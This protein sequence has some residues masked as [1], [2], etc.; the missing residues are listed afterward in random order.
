MQKNTTYYFLGAL[1]VFC[2]GVYG[3]F[4]NPFINKQQ[5][6]S[7]VA[8]TTSYATSSTSF[9][10]VLVETEGSGTI[11]FTPGVQNT[12]PKPP[13]IRRT[14]T[15]ASS[16]SADVASLYRQK[17][18]DLQEALLKDSYNFSNWIDVGILYKQVGDYK[19]A[20]EAWNFASVISEK[21]IVS[22]NNLGDLYHYYLKDYPK[23]EQVLVRA[24]RNDE[25]YILSYINLADLYTN[26]YQTNT[27]KAELVLKDGLVKNPGDITL[28]LALGAYYKSR[29]NTESAKTIYNEVLTK[30]KTAKNQNLIDQVT[31]LLNELE[32]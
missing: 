9:G 12:A 19:G 30:A 6:E 21:N 22:F 26:S 14:I 25:A 31:A 5:T 32:K 17:I 28:S 1:L 16:I 10:D 8:T 20:E 24:I 4:E 18:I 3:F 23:A 15:I 13:I 11:N 27:N 2:L 29:G 7:T